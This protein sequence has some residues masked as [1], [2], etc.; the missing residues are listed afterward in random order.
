MRFEAGLT[1]YTKADMEASK[2]KIFGVH[3][4]LRSNND[5][6][7]IVEIAYHKN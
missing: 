2:P 5:D 6:L 3:A 4:S 7:S 1:T